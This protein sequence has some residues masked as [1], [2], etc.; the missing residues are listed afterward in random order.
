MNVIPL[1]GHGVLIFN[2]FTVRPENQQALVDC[3]RTAGDPGEIPGLRSQRVLRSLDGTQV[4]NHMHWD[5]E[6]A[7]R[8]GAAKVPWLT[9]ARKRVHDLIEGTG[10]QRFEIVS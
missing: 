3:I 2:V 8:Q 6:E 9:A 7:F 10:P 4:V 5:S 1:D